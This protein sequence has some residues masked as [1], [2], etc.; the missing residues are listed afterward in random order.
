MI[1]KTI[2]LKNQKEIIEFVSIVEQYSYPVTIS[3]NH[4]TMNAKSILG[5]LAIGFYRIMKM[6][7][8][9]EAAD[10]LLAAVDKFICEEHRQQVG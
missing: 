7:I 9:V 5:M 10:D 6:E 4:C 8:R 2:L 1:S 3:T